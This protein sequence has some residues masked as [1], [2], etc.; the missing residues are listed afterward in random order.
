[1]TDINAI[2]AENNRR[3]MRRRTP[4]DPMTGEGCC[5]PRERVITPWDGK[6]QWLPLS[7]L[8]DERYKMLTSRSA[9]LHLRIAHDFEFWAINCVKIHNKLEG[10]YMPFVLNAAQRRV[11]EVIEADRHAGR[12]LRIIMLKARQWGGSTL[13]Q[14]YF[15]WIQCVLKRAWNSLICAHVRSTA[16]QIR[17]MYSRMLIN[18]PADFWLEDQ[19]PELKSFEGMQGMKVIAGRDCQMTLA[20]SYGSDSVRGLDYVLAHLSEVAFWKDSE[21]IKPDEFINAITGG[22]PLIPLSFVAI[23]S[24]ANGQ[25]NFFHSEWIRAK[26]GKSLMRPVFVPWYEIEEYSM[27]VTNPEQLIETMDDYEKKLWKLGLTLEQIAWYR[28]KLSDFPCRSAMNAE[29][30]T[31]DVE[32][33]TATGSGVFDAGDVERM[34]KGCEEVLPSKGFMAADALTGADAL[35]HVHFVPSPNGEMEVWQPPEPPKP[36]AQ[37]ASSLN[38][39]YIVAVDVGGRSA[40]ADWSAITVFD[41]QAAPKPAIVAQWR[42]HCDHDILGWRAAMTARWYSDALLVIESN[43]LEAAAE[44]PSRYILEQINGV[45]PNLYVR[46]VRDSLSPELEQRLGFHTNRATKAMAISHLIAAVREG[47][48]TERSQLACNEMSTYEQLPNGSYA[49]RSGH[50][51]DLLMT[52]AI[53]LYVAAQLPPLPSSS[54]DKRFATLPHKAW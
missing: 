14:M 18:Y 38:S 2:I 45:Y 20:S 19:K 50:H 1:M 24:T 41:R 27:R 17:G 52:R 29:Y 35:S 6:P 54:S 16:A 49:A 12:P 30:P 47:A 53:A 3:K 25:G 11:L 21:L 9:Y 26:L 8:A 36:S 10:G 4:Y 31:D 13:I 33:F 28:T 40:K 48:Y 5:G 51:D 34:R 32:A 23:E 15:G 44:G 37:A 22:V 7:M 43:T 39:R 42:G 46:E